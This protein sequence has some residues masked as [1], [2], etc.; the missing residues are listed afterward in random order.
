MT[1]EQ[2]NHINHDKQDNRIENLEIMGPSE[3][4][5]ETSG[6]TKRKRLSEAEELAEYRKRYGP[7]DND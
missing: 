3:H 7:L 2:V 1:T 6:Y 4:S 5:R